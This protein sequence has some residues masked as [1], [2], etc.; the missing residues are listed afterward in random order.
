MDEGREAE[1]E[2]MEGGD[3]AETEGGVGM[4][5]GR[6]AGGGAGR[7]GV[8]CAG[9]PLDIARREK[10]NKKKNHLTNNITIIKRSCFCVL[11]LEKKKKKLFTWCD[12][13]VQVAREVTFLRGFANAGRKMP[14]F[15][16]KCR[17]T[18]SSSPTNLPG[19]HQKLFFSS[20]SF[21]LTLNFLGPIHF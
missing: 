16:G 11:L 13:G 19:E 3:G 1:T 17:W 9:I 14:S 4:E 20:F 6:E 8:G 5:E 15:I 7:G 10:R 21:L 12:D 18:R 2:G